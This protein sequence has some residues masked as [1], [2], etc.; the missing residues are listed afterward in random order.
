[1]AVAGIVLGWVRIGIVGLL[2]WSGSP[3]SRC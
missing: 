3:S 1:M 2:V